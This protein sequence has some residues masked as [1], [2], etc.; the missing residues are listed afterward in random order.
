MTN[1]IPHDR[2]FFLSNFCQDI[3]HELLNTGLKNPMYLEKDIEYCKEFLEFFPE[4]DEMRILNM[5]R[6]VIESLIRLCRLDDAKTHLDEL[7][8]D[9]PNNSWSYIA[10]GDMFLY[11]NES[12]KDLK[13]AKEFYDKALMYAKDEMDKEI[14][15]ERIEDTCE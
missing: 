15:E 11:G 6:T 4:E 1:S 7:L 3:E 10:Y 13:K 8:E 14:I 5:R 12:I 9:Y 2:S